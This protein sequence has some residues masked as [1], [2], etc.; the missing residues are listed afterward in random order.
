LYRSSIKKF[1]GLQGKINLGGRERKEQK[2]FE[3]KRAEHFPNLERKTD[4]QVQEAQRVV[5]HKLI[6]RKPPQDTS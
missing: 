3:S 6:Q 5:K 4:I 1:G 2:T